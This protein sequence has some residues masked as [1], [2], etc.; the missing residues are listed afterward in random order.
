M[1]S[2]PLEECRFME[3]P[4]PLFFANKRLTNHMI[5]V[6][7]ILD[8]DLCELMCYQE[9]N[10]VSFNLKKNPENG[11]VK[12]RCELNNS[13]HLEHDRE[14]RDDTSYFYRGAKVWVTETSIIS[15]QIKSYPRL[16]RDS[17]EG[18]N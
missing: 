17:V 12:H 3:F 13:T 9:P 14:F 6:I 18:K 10:C 16:M 1:L 7:G 15:H 2:I 5:K 11:E 8:M 4:A